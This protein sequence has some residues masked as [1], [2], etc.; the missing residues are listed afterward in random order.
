[1][2]FENNLKRNDMTWI[3]LRDALG[4]KQYLKEH[5]YMAKRK[6][7]EGSVRQLSCCYVF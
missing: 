3:S 4:K 2:M 5:R 1:M 6:A 7:E